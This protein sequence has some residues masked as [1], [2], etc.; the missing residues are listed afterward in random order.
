MIE[1][2]DLF[3]QQQS[4]RC[5]NTI[6]NHLLQRFTNH[7]GKGLGRLPSGEFYSSFIPDTLS[8][9]KLRLVF[10]VGRYGPIIDFR[11]DVLG[12]RICASSHLFS[13]TLQLFGHLQLLHVQIC[14]KCAY[15]ESAL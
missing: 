5:Y 9:M 10:H 8:E 7:M 2:K 12:E 3:S 1:V 15:V 11:L 6:P 14:N 4:N 13:Q